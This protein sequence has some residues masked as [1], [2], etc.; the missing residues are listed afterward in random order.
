MARRHWHLC[1]PFDRGREA[2]DPWRLLDRASIRSTHR[3]WNHPL[4]N[5]Y[6]VGLGLR[7]AKAAPADWEQRI[8]DSYVTALVEMGRERFADA[9]QAVNRGLA[10]DPKNVELLELE[11]LIEQSMKRR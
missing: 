1:R 11:T 3:F 4:N 9:R 5:S 10:L 6:G 2:R 7:C 8:R